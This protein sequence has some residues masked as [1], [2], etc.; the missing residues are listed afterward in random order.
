[1]AAEPGGGRR[2][3]LCAYAAG[4]RVSWLALDGEG[5]ALG[6]HTLVREAVSII[7]LCEVAEES[8]GGG[9]VAELRLRLAELRSTED[10]PGIG[11]AE[12]AAAELEQAIAAGPRVASPSYLDAVGAAATRLERTL[13]TLGASPFAEAMRSATPAVDDLAR[14]V[15]ENYKRPLG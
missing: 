12:V 2:V 1:M 8:A 13:G 3:Y 15:V 6:D 5:R 9:D 7:G 4:D 14:D 10:P 11:E